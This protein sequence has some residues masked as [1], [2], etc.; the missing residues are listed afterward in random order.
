[1]VI[2]TPR[3]YIPAN[4]RVRYAANVIAFPQGDWYGMLREE[5]E[6]STLLHHLRSNT[7]EPWWKH[8]RGRMGLSPEEQKALLPA[9]LTSNDTS[10]V[11]KQIHI[12]FQ[13][14]DR[15]RKVSVLPGCTLLEAA[16]SAD[17]PLEAVCG[18]NCE[19]ATCQVFVAPEWRSQLP[20][21][22]EQEE[23]MLEYAPGRRESSRL[24]CQIQLTP[25]MDGLEVI[26]PA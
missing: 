16:R 6:I 15:T 24:C 17:I 5:S 26:V 9:T 21:P 25:E 7:A 4:R 14:T 11:L 19:C 1:M 22:T 13:L 23:D 2:S 10:E 12:T 8:W 20:A 18:G 3:L